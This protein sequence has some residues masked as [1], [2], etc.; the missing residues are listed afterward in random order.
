MYARTFAIALALYPSP[1]PVILASPAYS[2]IFIPSG[3]QDNGFFHNALRNRT[4]KDP[5]DEWS[6]LARAFESPTCCPTIG[7][8][9]TGDS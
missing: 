3:D 5:H 2:N 7:K 4:L 8:A 9:E 1:T 6:D